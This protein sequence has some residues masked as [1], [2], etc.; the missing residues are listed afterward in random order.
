LLVAADIRFLAKRLLSR[1]VLLA[2]LVGLLLGASACFQPS[3]TGGGGGGAPWTGP[4]D[5]HDSALAGD[6]DDSAL[7]GDDDDS[8]AVGDDDSAGDDDSGDDDDDS[9]SGSLVLAPPTLCP[10]GFGQICLSGLCQY[11]TTF[12]VGLLEAAHSADP[13]VPSGMACFWNPAFL[14]SVIV[15][16]DN[17]HVRVLSVEDPPESHVERHGGTVTVTGGQTDPIA[18]TQSGPASCLASNISPGVT[19]LFE[20]GDVLEFIGSGGTDVPPFSAT[21]VAP[22]PIQGSPGMIEPGSAVTMAWS[23]GSGDFVELTLA[24]EDTVSGYAFAATCR[25]ADTGAA[26][27]PATITAFL[28]EEHGDWEVA[29]SRNEVEHF[30]YDAMGLVIEV[31]AQTSWAMEVSDQN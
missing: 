13:E 18:F 23:G 17:C 14:G 8:A 2:S 10:C 28:P 25:V 24:T 11:V 27:I 30:E 21:L 22:A 19:D 4:L 3:Q 16:E 20:E 7:A 12:A 15:N 26:V 29:F 5:D 31:V 9:A 1:F 6:D